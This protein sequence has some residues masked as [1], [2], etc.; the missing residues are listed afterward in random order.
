MAPTG[1]PIRA[2]KRFFENESDV[3]RFAYTVG[4]CDIMQ[5]ERVLMAVSGADTADV[6]KQAFWGPYALASILQLHRDFTPVA[7][8]AALS[9][10]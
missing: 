10:I 4:I 3:P 6:V 7:A 8:E 5:A 2:S 9:A 1:V